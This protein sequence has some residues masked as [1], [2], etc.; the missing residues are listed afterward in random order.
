MLL[1]HQ[2]LPLDRQLDAGE[3][4]EIAR[5]DDARVRDDARNGGA[6]HID[7]LWPD[8]QGHIARSG[9]Y[10][11]AQSRFG[12]KVTA[13]RAAFKD[14]A[15]AD[16]LRNEARRR[17]LINVLRRAYLFDAPSIHYG[18][19]VREHE[20]FFLIVCHEQGRDVN[21]VDK[22]SQLLP[23]ACPELCIEI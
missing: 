1:H 18:N 10:G 21:P 2:A 9:V 6:S 19:S 8:N 7:V 17:P 22:A 15:S 5:R 3:R 4:S 20:G 11:Q 16:E 14:R 12:D 13:I 23:Q